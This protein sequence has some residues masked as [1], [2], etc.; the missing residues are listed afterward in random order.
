MPGRDGFIRIHHVNTLNRARCGAQFATR[1]LECDDRVHQLRCAHDSVYRTGFD[2]DR[3]SD[4]AAFIDDSE[5]GRLFLT[6]FHIQGFE[7]A[8]EQIRQSSDTAFTAGWTLI[9]IR[10]T[11]GDCL[12]IRPATRI[13]TLSALRLWKESVDLF[14]DWILLRPQ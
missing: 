6:E 4:A 3:A 14:D 12:R 11:T 5:P 13:A 8:P 10:I 1:A 7:L 9:D 2:A